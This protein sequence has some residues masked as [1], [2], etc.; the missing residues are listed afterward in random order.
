MT[1]LQNLDWAE[2]IQLYRQG[3]LSLGDLC[4][5][6]RSARLSAAA[7]IELQTTIGLGRAL[8]RE[9]NRQSLRAIMSKY[10]G[11]AVTQLVTTVSLS[12][13]ASRL[14]SQYRTEKA[15]LAA[16]T[17]KPS[18][19]LKAL[20]DVHC[21]LQY[22]P[23]GGVEQSLELI[24]FLNDD[25]KLVVLPPSSDVVAIAVGGR[26]LTSEKGVFVL[27][28][29]SGSGDDGSDPL[30]ARE[31]ADLVCREMLITF[32]DGPQLAIIFA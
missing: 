28:L 18:A 11:Q 14:A 31:I 30:P 27:P 10:G 12:E 9:Q 15:A 26:P 25:W 6:A 4:E 3:D 16:A 7:Q 13:A 8:E 22:A 32:R 20:C 29:K 23:P 17:A 2:A 5:Y 19:N 21:T 24:R 1:K